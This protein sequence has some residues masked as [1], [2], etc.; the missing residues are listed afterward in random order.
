MT[1]SHD[2]T[3]GTVFIVDDDLQL[4]KFLDETL[5]SEGYAA[6]SF[7]DGLD[8][9]ENVRDYPVPSVILLDVFMNR[10]DG[11]EVHAE[12][13]ERDVCVPIVFLTTHGNL[14]KATTALKL[15]AVDYL[16]KPADLDEIIAALDAA[17]ET[18]WARPEK[19][20]LLSSY[21]KLAPREREVFVHTANGRLEKQTANAMDIS[22]NTVK[23]YKQQIKEKMGA[24]SLQS[25]ALMA[26]QL[27]LIEKKPPT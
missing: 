16:E 13:I 7:P 21:K 14:K 1:K 20:A 25:M 2:G 23:Y 22:I 17:L 15:G 19:E 26:L 27:G 11:H 10:M 12:L 24:D 5:T 4:R 18:D 9:L 3:K 8:L 6:R